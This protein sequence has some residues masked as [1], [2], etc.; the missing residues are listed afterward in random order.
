MVHL[1]RLGEGDLLC[2]MTID[3]SN[4]LC[5]VRGER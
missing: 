3:S 4:G 1:A 5:I 2:D